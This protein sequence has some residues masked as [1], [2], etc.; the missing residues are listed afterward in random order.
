MKYRK[1]P[2]T[3]M[4]ISVVGF[5]CWPLGGEY[6]GPTN[7]AAHHAAVRAALDAGI[8]WFDTAP[9]YGKGRAD[10]V[11]VEALGEDRGEVCDGKV[12]ESPLR[13]ELMRELKSLGNY[14]SRPRRLAVSCGRGDGKRSVEPGR[15]ASP[16]REESPSPFMDST[17]WVALGAPVTGGVRRASMS[18]HGSHPVVPTRNKAQRSEGAT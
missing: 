5:G 3:E 11:L 1:L 16:A 7:E 6:W 17:I 14:P 8:N 18:R 15:K 9:L 4:E 10:E 2:G 12:Q 13:K